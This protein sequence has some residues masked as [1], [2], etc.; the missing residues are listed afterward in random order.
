MDFNFYTMQA[1]NDPDVYK[2]TTIVIRLLYYSLK[3]FICEIE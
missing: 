2:L 3:L 1:M